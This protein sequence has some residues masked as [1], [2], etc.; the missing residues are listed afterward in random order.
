[1]AHFFFFFPLAKRT[2]RE[3]KSDSIT[4]CDRDHG[5]FTDMIAKTRR[6]RRR[7]K[8]PPRSSDYAERDGQRTVRGVAFHV[9]IKNAER[10]T[11]SIRSAPLPRS[12]RYGAGDGTKRVT[13][14]YAVRI[15]ETL[16]LTRYRKIENEKP[17]C[18]AP[19][20]VISIARPRTLRSFFFIT[21]IRIDRSCARRRRRRGVSCRQFYRFHVLRPCAYIVKR[22]IIVF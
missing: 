2:K 8:R 12:S 13:T 5:L 9:P 18:G 7:R 21:K 4:D 1:M 6:R 3:R 22:M 11:N 20:P 17:E 19:R 14:P 16:T 10:L 15:T